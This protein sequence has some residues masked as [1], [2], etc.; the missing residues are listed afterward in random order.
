MI[1]ATELLQGI[2]NR[3]AFQSQANAIVFLI[4]LFGN[5]VVNQDLADDVSG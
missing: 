1:A 3:A 2:G 4:A 5:N